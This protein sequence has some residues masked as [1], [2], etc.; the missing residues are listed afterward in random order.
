MHARTGS[1]KTECPQQ[2]YNRDRGIS[3]ATQL[4]RH[5]LAIRFV[6]SRRRGKMMTN[7]TR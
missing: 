4:L 5:S 1:Q 3:K 7:V 2:R 6:H